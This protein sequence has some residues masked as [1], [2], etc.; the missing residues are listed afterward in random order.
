VIPQATVFDRGLKAGYYAGYWHR[1]FD[2]F[3]PRDLKP[4]E[5]KDY[6]RGYNAGYALGESDDEDS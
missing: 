2:D 4:E 6:K 5:V 3:P 1:Q